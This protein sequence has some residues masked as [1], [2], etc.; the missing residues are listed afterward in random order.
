MGIISN[1]FSV[2]MDNLFGKNHNILIPTASFILQNVTFDQVNSLTLNQDDGY[3]ISL[4]A[5]LVINPCITKII[6]SESISEASYIL[7]AAMEYSKTS[8]VKSALDQGFI[9]EIPTPQ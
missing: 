5:G 8:I 1:I 7:L 6:V 9:N 3:K 4:S 2:K